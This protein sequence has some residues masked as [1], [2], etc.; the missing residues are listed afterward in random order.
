M[1]WTARACW[2]L[3]STLAWAGLGVGN[4]RSGIATSTSVP[5]STRPSITP[6]EHCASA[7]S[8]LLARTRPSAAISS[9]RLRAGVMR[10]GCGRA[11]VELDAEARLDGLEHGGRAHH[12]AHHHAERGERVARHP[13]GK[14]QRDG[15]QRRHLGQASGD[16]LELLVGDRLAGIAERAVPDHA[17]AGLRS[18]GHQHEGAGARLDIGRQQVVVGLVERHGQQHGHARAIGRR[19]PAGLHRA[20]R[21]GFP[22]RVPATRSDRARIEGIA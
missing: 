20:V 16:G 4:R 11:R 5:A 9:A 3:N 21:A 13:L 15:R 6:V 7:A 8:A 14:A 22:N 19:P 17:D 2:S 1:A 12:H 10:G 18:E